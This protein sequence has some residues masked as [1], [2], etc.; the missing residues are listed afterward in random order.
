M[1]ARLR[2]LLRTAWAILPG[3]LAVATLVLPA[4]LF[5]ISVQRK[6]GRRVLVPGPT[7]S[8]HHQIEER[9]ESCHTPFGGVSEAACLRCHEAALVRQDDSHAVARFDDP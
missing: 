6:A 2:L 5:A 4:T 8:G 9:C 3:A 7:S 1:L